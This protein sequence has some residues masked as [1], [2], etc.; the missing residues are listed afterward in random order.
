M[1]ENSQIHGNDVEP[2]RAAD[3]TPEEVKKK[4]IFNKHNST[5]PIKKQ[6]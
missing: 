2:S 1:Q 5:N 3:T 6:K 4:N